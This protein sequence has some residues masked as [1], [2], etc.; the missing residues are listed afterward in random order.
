MPGLLPLLIVALAAAAIA[1]VLSG[2][3]V[4]RRERRLDAR[5]GLA[6]AA[7]L[8]ATGAATAVGKLPM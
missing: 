7:L 4:L 5:H 8:V 6:S 2:V 3:V 1:A